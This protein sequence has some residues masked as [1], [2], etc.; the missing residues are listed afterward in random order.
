MDIYIYIYGIVPFPNDTKSFASLHAF[1][2]YIFENHNFISRDFKTIQ[3]LDEDPDAYDSDSSSD[4]DDDD[5]DDESDDGSGSIEDADVEIAGVDVPSAVAT[6]AEP[7][8]V[9]A[10]PH[11]GAAVPSPGSQPISPA[12]EGPIEAHSGPAPGN[13]FNLLMWMKPT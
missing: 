6:N 11:Q 1:D 4:D 3:E 5:D 13:L 8:T 12:I 7:S 10:T 9:P 2:L